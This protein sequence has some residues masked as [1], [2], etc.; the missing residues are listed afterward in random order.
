ML[1]LSAIMFVLVCA[2]A[3]LK[4]PPVKDAILLSAAITAWSFWPSILACLAGT[5][6]ARKEMSKKAANL[7]LAAAIAWNAVA[8]PLVS[9]VL[10]ER[11]AGP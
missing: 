10:F 2:H 8:I 3:L 1:A 9:L 4:V 11:S 5:Y 7:L 6:L